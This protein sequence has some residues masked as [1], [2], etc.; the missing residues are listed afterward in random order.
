MLQSIISIDKNIIIR[1]EKAKFVTFTFLTLDFKATK[2][3][4][5]L[6]CSVFI[7]E[8]TNVYMIYIYFNEFIK[9]K[10]NNECE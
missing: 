10:I 4:T 6:Y 3:K 5:N 7:L 9:N 8:N 2:K 1:K